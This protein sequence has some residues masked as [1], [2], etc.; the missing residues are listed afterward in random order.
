MYN[1]VRRRPRLSGCCPIGWSEG[2]VGDHMRKELNASCRN[3]KGLLLNNPHQLGR[4]NEVVEGRGERE[5]R[6]NQPARTRQLGSGAPRK[7]NGTR[8]LLFAKRE[9]GLE[10]GHSKEERERGKEKEREISRSA[11]FAEA[12]SASRVK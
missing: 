4:T 2:R 12:I 8:R 5:R 11:F 10:D 9:R 1:C 6:T 7:K 3:K